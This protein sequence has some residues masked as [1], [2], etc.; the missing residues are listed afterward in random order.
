MKNKIMITM[1]V[2]LFTSITSFSSPKELKSKINK[3]TDTLQLTE[4]Q[5]DLVKPILDQALNKKST[6]QEEIDSTSNKKRIKKLNK[7]MSKVD[8]NVAKEL[9][10]V[11]SED[12]MKELDKIKTELFQTT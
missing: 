8:S 10:E 5:Q 11:L 4:E 2:L 1:I 9:K 7:E 6:I 3:Y 12:Q